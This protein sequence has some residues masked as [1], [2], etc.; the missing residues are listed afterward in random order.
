MIDQLPEAQRLF[1]P[2][3]MNSH[4]DWEMSKQFGKIIIET[5]IQ[6]DVTESDAK[7]S[8]ELKLK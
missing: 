8:E 4:H 2:V 3:K 1:I 5:D 7:I 6:I